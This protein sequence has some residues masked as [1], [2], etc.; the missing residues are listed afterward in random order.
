M[1]QAVEVSVPPEKTDDLLA[2]LKDTQGLF[3]LQVQ[4]GTSVTPPGDV[5]H[6]RVRN[7]ALRPL[8][9]LLNERGVVDDAFNRVSTSEDASA[10]RAPRELT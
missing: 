5:I 9:R 8:L 1:W 6:A 4:R 7:S 3:S 10:S 2:A